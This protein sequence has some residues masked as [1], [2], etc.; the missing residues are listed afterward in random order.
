MHTGFLFYYNHCARYVLYF[1]AV[2]L[3]INILI[4]EMKGVWRRLLIA[5]MVRLRFY[6]MLL[7]ACCFF[8]P[9]LSY[10]KSLGVYGIVVQKK[11]TAPW[12]SSVL[13]LYLTC[14]KCCIL[15]TLMHTFSGKYFT[16]SKTRIHLKVEAW[17]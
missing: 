15:W 3:M 13:L 1:L 6:P 10:L 9:K 2:T 7:I 8:P 14:K 4:L 5:P 11:D 17:H 12:I 16:I